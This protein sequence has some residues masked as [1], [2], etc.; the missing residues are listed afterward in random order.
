MKAV[1][2]TTLTQ[3]ELDAMTDTQLA[4][5]MNRKFVVKYAD[6]YEQGLHYHTTN[7]EKAKQM[8]Y[9]DAVECMMDKA[10]TMRIQ[11]EVLELV[12]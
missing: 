5:R 7:L 10:R 9:F 3:S 8:S 6:G 1:T 12:N 2:P 11:G 4:A